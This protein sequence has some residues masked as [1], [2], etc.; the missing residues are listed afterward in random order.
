[1]TF[2]VKKIVCLV[3]QLLKIFDYLLQRT[4]SLISRMERKVEGL[5][6][7]EKEKIFFF[8][9]VMFGMLKKESMTNFVVH[10][11]YRYSTDEYKRYVKN[12]YYM[13]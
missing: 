10:Y 7:G 13:F 8:F 1:M 12:Y 2:D 3:W 6:V 5:K 11:I 4:Y 9:W